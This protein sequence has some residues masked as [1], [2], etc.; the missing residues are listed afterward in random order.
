[1]SSQDIPSRVKPVAGMVTQMALKLAA[2]VRPAS[3][4]E[5]SASEQRAASLAHVARP[6]P[7]KAPVACA[8]PAVHL[9][10]AAEQESLLCEKL[11][12]SVQRLASF[13]T[14]VGLQAA[15]S[16]EPG[17]RGTSSHCRAR[18]RR[19]SSCGLGPWSQ[20]EVASCEKLVAGVE[21][22]VYANQP[23]VRHPWQAWDQ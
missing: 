9:Q 3:S 7:S 20:L 5:P 18:G 1:M 14:S 23:Q 16:M 4:V 13:E 8:Q 11:V 10:P 21:P 19:E 12:A 22:A 17:R 15:A 2:R 6:E